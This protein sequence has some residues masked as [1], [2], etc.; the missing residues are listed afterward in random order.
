MG[1]CLCLGLSKRTISSTSTHNVNRKLFSTHS[2]QSLTSEHELSSSRI[3]ASSTLARR[4]QY[5]SVGNALEHQASNEN[6]AANI[7]PFGVGVLTHVDEV[8]YGREAGNN[9]IR[10]SSRPLV[11]SAAASDSSMNSISERPNVSTKVQNNIENLKNSMLQLSSIARFVMQPIVNFG[12][13][14]ANESK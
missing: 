4:P 13:Q 11:S 2:Q 5:S 8:S 3:A 9:P 10:S 12:V 1:M 14:N 7:Q 6:N